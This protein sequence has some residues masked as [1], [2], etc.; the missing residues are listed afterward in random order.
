MAENLSRRP[1]PTTARAIGCA[2][3]I[4]AL[5]AAIYAPVRHHEYLD[6]DDMAY[7]VWNPDLQAGS[8]RDALATAFGGSLASCW[9]PLTVLTHQLDRVLW[10]REAAGALL[11]NAAL[12]ALGSIALLFALHRL[13]GRLAASAWVAA[14]HAVHPLHVESVA[15]AIERKDAL[16]ALWFALLLWTYARQVEAPGSRGRYWASIG[17]LGL[18][19]L[20]KPMLVTAPFVL[21]LLDY[22]PLQR[23]DRAAVREKLP[24][25]AMVAL[26]SYVTWF[27]QRSTGALSF[28]TALPLGA[29]FENALD[30]LV[31]YL[32][33][34]FW[35]TQLAAYY[36]H[37]GSSLSTFHVA[38]CA[39]LLAAVTA[40]AWLLRKR[41]PWLLVGWLWYLGMLVPVLGLVQVGM[42][43]RADRYTYLPLIGIALAL[44]F[45]VDSWCRTPVRRRLAATA[46]VVGVASLAA[47]AVPQVETWRNSR[48]LYGR[49]RSVHPDAAFPELRLGM[50]DA[51]EGDFAAAAP[52]LE[53]AYQLDPGSAGEAAQQL[54]ALAQFHFAHGRSEQAVDTAR[55]A[56][57]FAERTGRSDRAQ[58]L[59]I[60]LRTLEHAI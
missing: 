32:G 31:A 38:G 26:V 50:V 30:A 13:T 56:I 60:L 3:V 17:C 11:E 2:A 7:L 15:W 1:A 59:R 58:D 22:W 42:Q 25:F 49:M 34:A 12:H 53:R 6:Y 9:V 8:L 21:L 52:H 35:P 44:A 48:S 33:D 10:G 40:A 4:A 39:A 47:A 23:L 46:G 54:E 37:P 57:G 51:I 16:S 19:L 14:V 24:M 43:A 18:G 41:R 45:E 27:V 20:S 55:W 29:R 36:P 5:V 28:G